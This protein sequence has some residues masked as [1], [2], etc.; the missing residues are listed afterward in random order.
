MLRFSFGHLDARR[1]S[2]HTSVVPFAQEVVEELLSVS[3]VS[4]EILPL[5]KGI[6]YAALLGSLTVAVGTHCAAALDLVI[7]R[8][9]GLV[10]LQHVFSFS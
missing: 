10:V 1:S 8:M 5:W 9:V 7:S 6:E 4:K 3:S 2:G